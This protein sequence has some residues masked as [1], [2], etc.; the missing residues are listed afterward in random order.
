MHYPE[1]RVGMGARGLGLPGLGLVGITAGLAQLARTGAPLWVLLGLPVLLVVLYALTR[2]AFRRSATLTG[3]EGVE[4]RGPFGGRF[5]AWRDVQAIEVEGNPAAAVDAGVARE[6]VHL[7]DRQGHQVLLPHVNSR[8]L[9]ALHEDVRELRAL[10]ELRRGPD[11]AALPEAA[12]R[13]ARARRSTD[14][15][16]AWLRGIAAGA[17]AMVVTAVAFVALLLGG[18]LDDLDGPAAAL[19]SPVMIMVVPGVVCAA[20]V[21]VAEVLRRRGRDRERH[22]RRRPLRQAAAPS[23]H[24]LRGCGGG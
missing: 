6:F 7:Y 21:A 3:P 14:R 20:V 11:W 24:H 9:F 18:A 1:Y 19:L 4:A 15:N 16:S 22:R 2:V 10:W 8:N 5:V 13:I 12:A 23:R 17:G